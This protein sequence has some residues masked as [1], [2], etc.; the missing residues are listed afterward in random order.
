[1]ANDIAS[2]RLL[3]YFVYATFIYLSSCG[4]HFTNRAEVPVCV[5]LI[6]NDETGVLTSAII[7]E[8]S[9]LGPLTYGG[10]DAAYELV[11]KIIKNQKEDI[12]YQYQTNGTSG[13][14]Q[15]KLSNVEGRGLIKTE[16]LLRSKNSGDVLF[17]PIAVEAQLEYDYSD[18]R[19]F[20]DLAFVSPNG[21]VETYLNVSLGQLDSEEDA[22]IIAKQRLYRELAKKIVKTANFAQMTQVYT[23]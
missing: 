17:G 14:I 11:V 16:V 13:E 20:T 23:K 2:Y 4:Y 15:N 18:N 1:L 8:L 9:D 12:G 22:S 10:S 21:R 7:R 6:G 3:N 19:S 5:S